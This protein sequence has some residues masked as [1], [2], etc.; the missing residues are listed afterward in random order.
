MKSDLSRRLTDLLKKSSEPSGSRDPIAPIDS[1]PA[2]GSLFVLDLPIEVPVLWCLVSAHPSDS[3]LWFTVP[4][5]EMYL[6]GQKDVE[7]PRTNMGRCIRLRCG[8][9]TWIHED[10]LLAGNQIDALDLIY[11]EQVADR[12]ARWAND[13]LPE[14]EL[15]VETESD[16][17]YVD[18]MEELSAAIAALED[19][20]H[21][22]GEIAS[23]IEKRSISFSA[24]WH[25]EIP[26]FESPILSLAAD[27]GGIE[28]VPDVE[29]ERPLGSIL[30]SNDKGVLVAL[31][32]SDGVVFQLFDSP[33]HSAPPRVVVNG[34]EVGWELLGD[35]L[36]TTKQHWQ[37]SQIA[38]SV[39]DVLY[40]PIKR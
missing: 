1:A 9:G 37:G 5:D 16:P 11:V 38:L 17:D 26:G 25:G 6:I 36:V 32:Y 12:L 24:N 29:S 33:D 18:W 30:Q 39:D 10:D 15:L 40:E 4:G 2:S 31:K 28:T 35:W 20:M 22:G 8:S 3:K 19:S 7:V 34:V 13:D 27:S 14:L 21:F 23:T